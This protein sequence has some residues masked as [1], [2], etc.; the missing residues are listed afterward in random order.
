VRIPVSNRGAVQ[1]CM[2]KG[3]SSPVSTFLGLPTC[4]IISCAGIVLIVAIMFIASFLL[5]G[6]CEV[7]SRCRG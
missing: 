6:G 3:T 7:Y 1:G 5:Q 4:D 2:C